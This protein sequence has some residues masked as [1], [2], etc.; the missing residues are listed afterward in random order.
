M[1]RWNFNL[2]SVLH[3]RVREVAIEVYK[4]F[5][6]LLYIEKA[7]KITRICLIGRIY[8]DVWDMLRMGVS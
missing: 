5:L 1:E 8:S 6:L 7:S 3:K 2:H 4:D